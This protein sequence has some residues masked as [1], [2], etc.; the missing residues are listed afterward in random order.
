M[1]DSLVE[2]T[3]SL[4]I[5]QGYF[6]GVLTYKDSTISKIPNPCD[7]NSMAPNEICSKL[8]YSLEVQGR[9]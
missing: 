5:M 7:S 1:P 9:N 8:L 6:P 3:Y 2:P 4:I